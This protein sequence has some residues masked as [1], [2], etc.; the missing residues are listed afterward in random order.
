M[1]SKNTISLS[2]IKADDILGIWLT[3][4][5]EPAKI[6]IYKSGQKYYGKIVWLQNPLNNGKPKLDINNSDKL[7][8]NK[9]ILGLIILIGLEFDGNEWNE[10]KIY[11][12]ESGK[13][14]SCQ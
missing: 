8:R 12:P 9:Q 10:G 14:Y 6:Q 13:I 3:S 11:D 7:N 4:G 5:K 2:Q 1:L